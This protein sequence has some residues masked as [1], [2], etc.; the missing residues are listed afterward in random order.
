MCSI[1]AQRIAEIGQAIDALAVQAWPAA[2]DTERI[3]ARL[4]ELWGLLAELDPEVARRL[5]GYQNLSALTDLW[6]TYQLGCAAPSR[7]PD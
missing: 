5:A 6:P 4:A 7:P 1:A 2:S 3:V